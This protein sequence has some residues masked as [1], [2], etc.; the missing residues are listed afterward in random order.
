MQTRLRRLLK[1]TLRMRTGP[2]IVCKVRPEEF[3]D[4][5]LDVNIGSSVNPMRIV[6]RCW[7][8]AWA[9]GPG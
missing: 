7:S 3:L 2:I 4:L 8:K 5:R 9:K 1:Q 6:T